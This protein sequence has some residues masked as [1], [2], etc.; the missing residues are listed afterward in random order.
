MARV[1]RARAR[2]RDFWK[3]LASKRAA[4]FFTYSTCIAGAEILPT[5]SQLTSPQSDRPDFAISTLKPIY[6]HFREKSAF[7]SR[8]PL[9]SG[10]GGRVLKIGGR[11]G[12]VVLLTW[13][14]RWVRGMHRFRAGAQHMSVG[15]A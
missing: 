2:L 15:G 3:V 13:Y 5:G 9:K 6:G 10:V 14:E 1:I 8:A 7:S 11:H 12:A 4:T